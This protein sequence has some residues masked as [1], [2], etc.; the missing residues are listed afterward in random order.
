V[1]LTDRQ[2]RAIDNA[3]KAMRESLKAAYPSPQDFGVL[4]LC[5]VTGAFATLASS[6]AGSPL[7][8]V[9]NAELKSANLT[10]SRRSG[11]GAPNHP[12]TKRA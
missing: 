3:T 8:A 5:A 11:F 4:Y 2:Q 12:L 10:L 7:M 6:A 9:I 1:E